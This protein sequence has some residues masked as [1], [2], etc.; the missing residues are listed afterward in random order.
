MAHKKTTSK[1][2]ATKASRLL[3][4]GRTSKKVKSVAGSAL[5]QKHGRKKKK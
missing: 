2:V 4:S 3:R 5:T 1:R